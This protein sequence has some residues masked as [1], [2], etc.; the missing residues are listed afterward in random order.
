MHECSK[1]DS[2]KYL[3]KRHTNGVPSSIRFHPFVLR[4]RMILKWQMVEGW[5]AALPFLVT[6]E[7]TR[8]RGTFYLQRKPHPEASGERLFVILTCQPL[9]FKRNLVPGEAQ[10]R[11][12][13]SFMLNSCVSCK[14]RKRLSSH[15]PED[16]CCLIFIATLLCVPHSHPVNCEVFK[17]VRDV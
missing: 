10:L 16:S 3:K 7:R 4:K 8:A 12:W 1:S 11:E 13:C 2:I 6:D 17:I 15:P 9:L 14:S 5:R